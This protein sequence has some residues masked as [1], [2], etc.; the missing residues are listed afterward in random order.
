MEHNQ[1]HATSPLEYIVVR[2]E[3]TDTGFGI[4]PQDMVESK[5]FCELFC[6]QRSKLYSEFALAAFNQ[7]EQGRQQGGKGTG[8]GLALVRQIV[9]LSGGRLGVR[10]KAG[11]GS[12]FWVELPLGVGIKTVQS[13]HDSSETSDFDA[14]QPHR[15]LRKESTGSAA[16]RKNVLPSVNFG[17]AKRSRR[18]DTAMQGIMEQGGL[19]EIKLGKSFDGT[20]SQTLPTLI[21]E[22]VKQASSELSQTLVDSASTLLA[23]VEGVEQGTGLKVTIIEQN[24]D[25][26]ESSNA[27]ATL[28]QRPTYVKL[29]SPKVFSIEGEVQPP[30]TELTTDASLSDRSSLNLK[31]FDENFVR[32]SPSMSF[33]TLNIEPGLPVLVVDD[34][35]I[36]RTLMKRILTR[37]GCQVTCAENGKVAL[38]IITGQQ[39][40]SDL[41]TSA[42]G[43]SSG[44]ATESEHLHSS[45]HD[46]GKFAVVFLDNQ[47]PVMS[48][49]KVIEKLREMHR[50]DF[51]V[52][53]TGN[54]LLTGALIFP[55]WSER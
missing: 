47:M 32:G 13:Q 8:L 45:F 42:E 43:C 5:L 26:H 39:L 16:A 14:M 48:G 37:L 27:D 11:E 9:R 52:G 46:E 17:S 6:F 36:T 53:V 54:A 34:D 19:F 10:S 25:R 50:K 51:V 15:R 1:Q 3:V 12:T 55:P 38:E 41:T 35:S 21:V 44:P 20:T 40:P 28:L 7:T 49:L 30:L 22:P 31:K 2:I 4:K 29:P 24:D 18:I 23:N 33:T